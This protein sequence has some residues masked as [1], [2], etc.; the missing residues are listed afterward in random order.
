MMTLYFCSSVS[1]IAIK[2]KDWNNVN[3]T[4]IIAAIMMNDFL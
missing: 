2:V 1:L 4:M 3:S